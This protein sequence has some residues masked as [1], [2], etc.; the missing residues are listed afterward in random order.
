MPIYKFVCENCEYE[1]EKYFE[2][3]SDYKEEDIICPMCG[4]KVKK[5]IPN[6]IGVIYKTKGFYNTDFKKGD[7]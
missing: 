4:G 2:K 1:F 6:N 3:I 5:V 7:K